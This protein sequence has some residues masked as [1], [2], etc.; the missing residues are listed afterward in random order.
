ML[1][2]KIKFE[3]KCKL[4]NSI[5]VIKHVSPIK[6]DESIK[7]FCFDV[8]NLYINIPVDELIYIISNKLEENKES[9]EYIKQ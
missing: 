3:S 5:N 8:K 4:K 2:Q 7:L 6:T 1:N 9:I